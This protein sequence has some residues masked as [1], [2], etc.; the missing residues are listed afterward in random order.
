MSAVHPTAWSLLPLLAVLVVAAVAHAIWEQRREPGAVPLLALTVAS[1]W[2]A[3]TQFLLLNLRQPEAVFALTRLQYVGLA[4][5]PFAWLWFALAYTGRSGLLLGPL[6]LV[7]SVPVA[8]VI[9]A[10]GEPRRGSA[11]VVQ[12]P[13]VPV[14]LQSPGVDASLGHAL[15][16]GYGYLLV[17]AATGILMWHHAQ[18][19]RQRRRIVTALLAP[20]VVAIPHLVSL[21]YL[22]TG[23][24]LDLTP[25][26]FAL[27]SAV[28]AWGLLREGRLE[29]APVARTQVVEEM[30]DPVLVLDAR[31]HIVDLNRAARDGLGLDVE[32]DVPV[33]LGTTWAAERHRSGRLAPRQVT[34]PAAGGEERIFET[35]LTALT[36][37]SVYE[38]TVLVLR[39]VTDRVRMEEELKEKSHALREANAELERLAN[40]DVLT[41]LANRRQFMMSLRREVGRSHRYGRAVSLILLDLDRFKAVN[42]TYGHP[43]GDSVLRAVGLVLR[44]I[45]REMDVP[46]RLGGEEFAVLLPETDAEGARAVAER[47]RGKLAALEHTGPD[48]SR[49]RVTA[50]LGVAELAA[51][52]G[53]APRLHHAADRALY[54]AKA[55]GRDRVV[56]AEGNGASGEGA[57][58]PTSDRT[59]GRGTGAITG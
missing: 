7:A 24:R 15:L 34:L 12:D 37:W 2:W 40:T 55:G 27:A 6:G 22:G 52:G 3:L 56:A 10:L 58:E 16:A 8:G 11:W 45:S 21:S 33:A 18:S 4:A 25:T 59:P 49:F 28:L 50:S 57:D 9:L 43:A 1:G 48:G 41:G 13:V 39:D 23:V 19:P 35:T 26:G 46:A 44:D 14:G 30:R 42:D 17:L 51:A 20:A 53:T 5:A 47:L 54:E 29:A 36:P 38:R 32:G 31:G